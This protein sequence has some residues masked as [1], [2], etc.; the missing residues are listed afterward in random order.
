MTNLDDELVEIIEP[1]DKA[2]KA[3]DE[4]L[5]DSKVGSPRLMAIADGLDYALARADKERAEKHTQELVDL[6]DYPG[7]FKLLP[8][9]V[10][11]SSY[12]NSVGSRIDGR[13]T[14]YDGYNA[15]SNQVDFLIKDLHSAIDVTKVWTTE[16]SFG[17]M[18]REEAVWQQ[19]SDTIGP[20]IA[21]LL[22]GQL[23]KRT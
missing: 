13:K 2:I 4:F 3:I 19:V 10:D 12:M 1:V 23:L 8:S 7:A 16:H 21:T 22:A 9:F 11:K 17:G 14:E 20:K 6:K 18:T 5:Q 15:A